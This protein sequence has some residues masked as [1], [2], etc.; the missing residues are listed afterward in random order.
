M[1]LREFI[2]GNNQTGLVTT[3]ADGSVMVVGGEDPALASDALKGQ[4]GIYIGTGFGDEITTTGVFTFPAETV[5]GFESYLA[6]A[7][8]TASNT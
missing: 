4:P 3:A 6:T 8:A 7:T 2:L 1:L 5:A